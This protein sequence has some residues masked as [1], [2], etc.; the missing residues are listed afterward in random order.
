[1][2]IAEYLLALFHELERLWPTATY[3]A[4]SH[5]VA[6][7]KDR[8]LVLLI[9]EGDFAFCCAFTEMSDDPVATAAR[10]AAHGRAEYAKPYPDDHMIGFDRPGR[11]AMMTKKKSSRLSEAVPGDKPLPT[12]T[13]A[14]TREERIRALE[15]WIVADGHARSF[16]QFRRAYSQTRGSLATALG[17]SRDT[18]AAIESRRGTIQP[19]DDLL[20]RFRELELKYQAQFP[21]TDHR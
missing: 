12:S 3:N 2:P 18:I 15:N 11:R 13:K 17:C 21:N 9:N 10:L 1:M 19:G 20:Q 8:R 16:K 7:D 6:W 4:V 5:G 14:S